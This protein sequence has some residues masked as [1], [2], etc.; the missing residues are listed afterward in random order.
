MV[1]NFLQI[2]VKFTLVVVFVLFALIL[3]LPVPVI[4][5]I[6]HCIWVCYTVLCSSKTAA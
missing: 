5:E 4:A 3:F 6:L 1:F 2:Y